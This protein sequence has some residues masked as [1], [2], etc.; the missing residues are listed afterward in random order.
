MLRALAN[1]YRLG[2]KELA[3]LR[4]DPVML[5][6]VVYAFSLA[7]YSVSQGAN[8]EVHNASVAIVDSDHSELSR[9]IAAALLPPYFKAPRQLNREAAEQALDG[10]EATFVLDFPPAMES[11]L[12]EGREVEVQL[13]VDATA[14]SQA[15]IG[16]GYIQQIVE[17]ETTDFLES[18]GLS[19]GSPIA[20]V[21]RAAFNPNLQSAW[22]SSIMQ[23]INSITILAIML[24]GAAVIRER[25]HG[26][27]EHLLVMPLRPAEIALA[28]IWANGLVV[29]VATALSLL[30]VVEGVL[31]VPIQGSL[32]LF[33]A[34]TAL[35]LFAVTSLGIMLATIARSMPQFGLLAIPVFV[36]MNL[37]SGSTTPMESMP[38][39]LQLVMQASP[40]VHF[41]ALSQAI[42]YRGAGVSV[43]WPQ[44]LAIAGLGALCLAVALLRFKRMLATQG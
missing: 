32:A 24:V 8:T 12:L 44:L 2:L 18:R 19:S 4:Y 23:V 3:S 40:S 1:V 42:L 5:L 15:G 20:V 37:L 35:Y 16:T 36:I 14:V 34:S 39:P 43:I 27:I 28:K 25:E 17:R 29:L 22:F 31:G 9:R 41:V 10:G 26:T 38:L 21:I 30:L 7:V 6:L 13:L 11:D 33:L